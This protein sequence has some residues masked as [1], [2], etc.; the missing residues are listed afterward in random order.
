MSV[1]RQSSRPVASSNGGPAAASHSSVANYAVISTEVL[2]MLFEFICALTLSKYVAYS[3]VQNINPTLTD[4][5]W[6][7]LAINAICNILVLY[8]VLL[9]FSTRLNLS[10][11]QFLSSINT[12]TKL[13]VTTYTVLTAHTFGF[14]A[15]YIYDVYYNTQKTYLTMDNWYVTQ[16]INLSNNRE[17]NYTQ[18][19]D[20][21]LFAPVREEVV[22]RGVI[23]T[24]LM[25]KLVSGS[26]QKSTQMLNCVI[27][28]LVFGSI[29]LLNLFSSTTTYSSTYCAAQIL[30][31]VCV[32]IFYCLHLTLYNSLT[33]LI[34]MH[35]CNNLFSSFVPLNLTV[36]LTSDVVLLMSLSATFVLYALLNVLLTK[37]LFDQPYKQF[38]TPPSKLHDV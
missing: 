32:G 31:G 2:F 21:I 3:F 15:F 23:L 20:M 14:L 16:S 35:C 30:L 25:Y 12:F 7:Q 34:L 22:F 29:H 36:N 11:P 6:V 24:Y 33:E 19:A 17:M 10:I 8:Y 5:Q 9:R 4:N 27:G 26:N 37:Q 38:D 28:G 1:T 18:I 13:H